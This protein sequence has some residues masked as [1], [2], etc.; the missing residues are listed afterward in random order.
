MSKTKKKRLGLYSKGSI[1]KLI[2][3]LV[4]PLCKQNVSLIFLDGFFH[5]LNERNLPLSARKFIRYNLREQL[6]QLSAD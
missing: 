2:D 5:S 4:H 3:D 6:K 1:N